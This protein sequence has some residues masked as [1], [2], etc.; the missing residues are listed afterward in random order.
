MQQKNG[1]S[2]IHVQTTYVKNKTL[3]RVGI[4]P[5]ENAIRFMQ[6]SKLNLC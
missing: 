4:T 6:Y 3:G 1:P 2:F 5:K